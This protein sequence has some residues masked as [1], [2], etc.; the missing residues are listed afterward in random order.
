MSDIWIPDPDEYRA[1]REDAV[2]YERSERGKLALTGED[3]AALLDG[4]LSNDIGRLDDGEGCW[5]SLL[6]PKGRM[7]AEVRVLRCPGEYALD[8]DRIS[9]QALWDAL[10]N[11]RIGHRVTLHKRTLQRGLLSVLGPRAA[12]LVGIA[13]A[14]EELRHVVAEIDGSPAR[15]VRTPLGLDVF[16][17]SEHS[18]QVAR[19]IGA[20][21]AGEATV[22]ALRV[23]L[24]RPRYG[25]DMDETT[26]PQEA[27]IHLRTVS[28]S[29]GC[30]VGQETVA[31]LYWKGKP[32]RH[33]RLLECS[34]PLE[35]GTPL[36]LEGA[37]VGHLASSIVS[38][39]RGP[40][41]LALV[42]RSAE[43]GSGLQAGSTG[44][45]ALVREIE[46]HS[47]TARP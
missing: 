7:L 35:R 38:P 19:A 1:A 31:R 10:N 22:E 15:V 40:L 42:R 36:A 26:M 41:A 46:A 39:E 23:E 33:L 28:Y 16:S 24:G 30:Y 20:R 11:M 17:H 6:T 9:L 25:V 13:P 34:E 14:A 3:A 29:K 18:E 44:A 27:G 45:T 21:S 4:L 8:T 47:V 43:P 5:A 12:E 37:Q 32:N 2:A